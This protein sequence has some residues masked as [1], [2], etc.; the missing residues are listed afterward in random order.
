MTIQEAEK[1]LGLERELTQEDLEGNWSTVLTYGDKVLLAG[2][3]YMGRGQNS[4]FGA[5]YEF[6]TKN[7]S[8]E[9]PIR[10]RMVSDVT[11]P[12]NGT[13]IAWALQNCFEPLT[14]D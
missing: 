1:T 2:H 10:L 5:V 8:C 11:F 6:T 9:S 12:D 3:W 7:H 13:A 14:L 4:Y